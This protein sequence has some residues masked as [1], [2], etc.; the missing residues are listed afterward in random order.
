MTLVQANEILSMWYDVDY[1]QS[2]PE[3]EK[4]KEALQLLRDE[5]TVIAEEA[6]RIN[7]GE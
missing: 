2:W 7:N 1:Y 3:S 5:R 4:I 6:R